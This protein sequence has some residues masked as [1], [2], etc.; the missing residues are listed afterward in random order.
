MPSGLTYKIY[1]GEELTLRDFALRCV[2]HIGAGYHASKQGD[3]PMPKDKAPV[4]KVSDY[5]YRRV[6]EAKEILA[7]WEGLKTNLEEA[8]KV[9]D[10]ILADNHTVNN[11]IK[12]EKRKIREYYDIMFTKVEN[13]NPPA[14]YNSLKEVM[15]KQLKDN[16]KWDGADYT[17]YDETK[18]NIPVEE[19]IET[20]IKIAKDDLEY[21]N[22]RLKEEEERILEYN[23]YLKG[24]YEALDE[25]EPLTDKEINTK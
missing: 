3:I 1:S 11:N 13:W 14:E 4:L 19:W 7:K 6:E 9:Y 16:S 18:K 12:E 17:L 21:Y 10:T 15:L 23:M 2:T 8:K 25:V 5:Y 20:N 22:K 24:L